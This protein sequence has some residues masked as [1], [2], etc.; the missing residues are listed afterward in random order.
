MARIIRSTRRL[1]LQSGTVFIT[2]SV[3][4]VISGIKAL[5]F[6]EVVEVALRAD[7]DNLA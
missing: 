1:H 5:G 3:G 4:Q 7:L 2:R 6:D